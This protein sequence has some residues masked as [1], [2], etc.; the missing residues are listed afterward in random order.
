MPKSTRSEVATV[1]T[2]VAH[3]VASVLASMDDLT[4]FLAFPKAIFSPVPA[5]ASRGGLSAP[6]IIRERLRRWTAGEVFA[7]YEEA[8][9]QATQ[10]VP[11]GTSSRLDT[12]RIR[13]TR[14][15]ARQGAF[16]KAAQ[17]LSSAPQAPSWTATVAGLQA[18][19]PPTVPGPVP[20]RSVLPPPTLISAL[21][22][23]S[24]LSGF[25]R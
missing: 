4:R 8:V 3:A 1:R 11:S 21:E 23:E 19:H 15:L 12:T 6:A 10:R 22:V 9:C 7:L 16:R 18:L 2:V 13:R 20:D 17:A 24:A 14:G 25:L 5:S